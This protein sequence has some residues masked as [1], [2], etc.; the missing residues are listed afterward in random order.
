[1]RMFLI[2]MSASM[3]AGMLTAPARGAGK[4]D[5][6]ATALFRSNCAPCHGFD[7]QGDGPVA[8][9]LAVKPQPLGTL[10][11]RH[12]GVFPYDYIYGVIDGRLAVRAHGSRDMPV[13]GTYFSEQHRGAKARDPATDLSTEQKIR[14]LVDHIRELQD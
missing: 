13:W 14:A 11:E 6:D 3:V 7:G 4:A 12:K 9:A 2:L 1:M 5:F 8:G 10:T